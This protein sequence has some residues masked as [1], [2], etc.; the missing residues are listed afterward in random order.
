MDEADAPIVFTHDDIS[1]PNILVSQ[2]PKPRVMAVIDWCQSGWYPAYWEY[3]KARNVGLQKPFFDKA[4]A[5]EWYFKY[6]PMIIDPVDEEKVYHPF[7]YFVL[8]R[9]I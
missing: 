4:E 8:S 2:G 9:G 1:P 6:L 3:C 5:E 7:F